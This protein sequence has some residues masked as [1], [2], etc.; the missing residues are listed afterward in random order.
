MN[1]RQQI[2]D[3][4]GGKT[5]LDA[6]LKKNLSWLKRSFDVNKN[7]GSSAYRHILGYWS[8]PYPETTGYL[9]PTLLLSSD[10]LKDA[11]LSDLAF[12]QLDCF[13]SLLS[14]S[15]AI[16]YNGKYYFFD[17]SQILLGLCE[18]YQS[19]PS[20]Q[21]R[22]LAE[23]IAAWMTDLID[24]DGSLTSNTFT[25]GYTPSYFSRSAW[26]LLKAAQQ[27]ETISSEA[28]IRL[29]YYI[30]KLKRS[31]NSFECWSF[32][33]NPQAFSHTIIYTLRGLWESSLILNDPQVRETSLSCIRTLTEM[34]K[35]HSGKLAGSYDPAWKGDYSYCCTAA[36]AQLA[37]LLMRVY[38]HLRDPFWLDTIG[39]LLYPLVYRQTIIHRA[40]IPSSLP[41]WG[42]YQRFRY[43]NWS[44]KF[45]S[46]ALLLLL[47][48]S[49]SRI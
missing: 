34:V 42:K 23:R 32:D 31:N 6:C 19:Q 7:K 33:G 43:T 44:Q 25:P 10:Y 27:F 8:T 15:G 37:V 28:A 26:A 29:L 48:S 14:E 36:N 17:N 16:E 1:P 39:P 46:D 9:L 3:Q 47:S 21:V 41:V 13:E 4:L 35:N 12:D 24:A 40:A 38:E 5:H 30:M 22:F 11:S 2:I 18:M 20:K 49:G 45:Y